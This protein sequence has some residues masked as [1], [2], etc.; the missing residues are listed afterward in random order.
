MTRAA[1]YSG[2]VQKLRDGNGLYLHVMPS[3]KYWRYD[4]RYGGKRKTLAIGVYPAVTL[5]QARIALYDAKAQLDNGIDPSYQK[6][7]AK[8]V[9]PDTTFTAVS[10][11]WL[12]QHDCTDRSRHDIRLRFEKDVWPVIG[13]QSVQAIG[14]R[15]V[16]Q[17]LRRIESRGAIDLAH[18]T[19]TNVSQAMR[20]A[21][22]TGLIDS[23]PCRDLK[24]ALKR[25]RRVKRYAAHMDKD[26]VRAA[27]NRGD[28]LE[29]RI[30]M[31]Q[32]WSDEIDVMRQSALAL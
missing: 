26:R 3:G 19:C 10:A 7:L 32:W 15:D 31:M 2:G 6:Q 5:K 4:Y 30:K 11:E 29:Q 8:Y 14:P 1:T 24:G 22:Y 13:S 27:Y 28:L 23:D 20:Y 9:N 16:L 21:V 17:C 18:R 12:A 25:K